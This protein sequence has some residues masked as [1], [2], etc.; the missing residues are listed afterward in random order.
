MKI[1]SAYI[2]CNSDNL[3]PQKK[4]KEEKISVMNLNISIKNIQLL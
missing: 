4:L 3:D 2:T 1:T